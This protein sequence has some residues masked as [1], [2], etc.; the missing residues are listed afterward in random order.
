MKNFYFILLGIFLLPTHMGLSV[1][2]LHHSNNQP[3]IDVANTIIEDKEFNELLK[4]IREENIKELIVTASLLTQ[5][6]IDA[7]QLCA[8]ECKGLR[9]ISNDGKPVGN[10]F[11]NWAPYLEEKKGIH[12]ISE[13]YES[14]RIALEL[15][16]KDYGH[17]PQLVLDFGCATGQDTIPLVLLGCQHV[18][19][20]DADEQALNIL[21]SN[22]PI[23]LSPFVQCMNRPFKELEID[24]RVDFF[25]SAFTF[26]YR[27]P[28]DFPSCWEKCINSM[29]PGGYLSGQFFGPKANKPP[30][31]GMTYHTESEVRA[32]LEKDFSILWFKIEPKDSQ[33]EVFGGSEPAWGDLYHFVAKKKSE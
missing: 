24:K 26:P 25:I 15:F 4:T 20:V 22:L 33:F 8:A 2:I 27:C 30:E 7:L 17:L 3:Y 23:H 11:T 1:E 19:A 28:K 31:I 14:T 9:I 16:Q 6:Q 29:V 12:H 18:I 5:N 10:L 32:L 13:M 21:K